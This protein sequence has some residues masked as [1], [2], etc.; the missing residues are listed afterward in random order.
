V[1]APDA[2][3]RWGAFVRSPS[4]PDRAH[5]AVGSGLK[6]LLPLFGL[7]LLLMAVLLGAMG[8]AI[9]LGFEMP[10]HMVAGM[11]MTPALLAFFV[12]GAPIGE[13]ILFRG[14]LSGRPGHVLGSLLLAGAFGL[15]MLGTRN[16]ESTGAELWSFGALG[17][18]VAA[19]LAVF[20]MRRRPAMPWFQRHFAWFY[21]VSVLLFAVVHLYNFADAGPA[22]LPLVMPQ[23][24]LAMILG[25]LRVTHGLWS[26]V[27]L[28][29]LHNSV[30]VAIMLA[31]GSAA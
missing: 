23:F 1:P 10:E 29:M 25:Y 12:L 31:G 13:E 11:K 9:A 5:P 28:H 30:F 22:L 24:A 27:L 6:T 2:W 14:W 15:L 3:R 16:V 21:W 17:A 20:L 19:G 7:D 26:C 8:A 4:L 18:M